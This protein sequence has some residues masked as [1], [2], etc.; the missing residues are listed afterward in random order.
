MSLFT[1]YRPLFVDGN[2]WCAL[3]GEN[4]QDGVDTPEKVKAFNEADK[5][6]MLR[7][8]LYWLMPEGTNK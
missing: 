6:N 3:Y 5:I 8:K 2:Q 1:L 4:I 7:D